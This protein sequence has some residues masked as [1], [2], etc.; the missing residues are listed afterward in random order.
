[1]ISAFDTSGLSVSEHRHNFIKSKIGSLSMKSLEFAQAYFCAQ[2]FSPF[3]SESYDIY[4]NYRNY[5]SDLRAANR[6][7]Q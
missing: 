4:G 6:Y 5:P 1:M 3:P 7:V 2:E